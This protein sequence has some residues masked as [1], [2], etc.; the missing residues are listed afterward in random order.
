MPPKKAVAG[1]Q[2]AE[3][4]G[5]CVH[6]A[7]AAERICQRCGDY[8]CSKDCQVQDW[9]R[10]RYICFPL[11]A[12]VYPKSHSV[13]QSS[14][15]LS[16]QGACSVDSDKTVVGA[17]LAPSPSLI[18]DVEGNKIC[19][20]SNIAPQN[21]VPILPTPP[22]QLISNNS[23]NKAKN[24]NISLPNAIMPPSNSLGIYD[25]IQVRESLLYSRC[26]RSC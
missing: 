12:L 21:K 23:G 9:P 22:T 20:T 4:K 3:G 10:H 14:H 19:S 2:L 25:G 17:T 7:V 11:P 24:K 16:L 6:C 26:Q 1:A 13:F 8:Y 18:P 15:E 5:K